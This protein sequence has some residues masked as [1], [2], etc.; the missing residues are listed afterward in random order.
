MNYEKSPHCERHSLQHR[1]GRTKVG[2]GTGSRPHYKTAPPLQHC[3]SSSTAVA[4]SGNI[5]S[6]PLSFP[7]YCSMQKWNDPVE[8]WS[9]QKETEM[10]KQRLLQH[11]FNRWGDEFS[12]FGVNWKLKSRVILKKPT[13]QN[14][15][16][17]SMNQINV[18]FMNVEIF[19]R[20]DYML[21]LKII[22]FC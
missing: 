21:L 11:P 14:G 22:Q 4:I 3:L 5:H 1:I 12:L 18:S 2:W 15:R 9:E 8:I 17:K 13:H 20:N 10:L 16:S 19:K 6:A 7:I